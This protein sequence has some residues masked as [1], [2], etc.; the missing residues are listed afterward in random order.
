MV[1]GAVQD[2]AAVIGAVVVAAVLLLTGWV[3]GVAAIVVLLV[4][5]LG[6]AGALLAV[7]AGL[8]VL[9]LGFVWGTLARTRRHSQLRAETRALWVATAVNAAGLLLRKG[10][11]ADGPAEPAG[12]G[13]GSHRSAL[14]IAGGLALI[15]LAFLL[16]SAGG[17]GTDPSDSGPDG[18]A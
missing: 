18:A 15:L 14:L 12:V 11:E 5:Y 8:V 9:A 3:L 7:T 13:T 10:P 4:P 2:R 17:E 1:A 6:A 16:P